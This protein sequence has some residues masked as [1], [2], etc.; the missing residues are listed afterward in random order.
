M[1]I[2]LTNDD[3]YQANGIHTLAKI[4]SK[5]GEVTVIA[6]KYTQSGMAMAINLTTKPIGYKFIGK[7][8]D[9]VSWAY[10]NSTPTAC[11]KYAL[12]YLVMKPDIIVSGI[13]H[14]SNAGA[15]S[16]YSG[17]LGACMEAAVNGLPSIGVS[18][19]D[20]TFI[21]DVDFS[22]VEQYFPEIFQ[23]IHDNLI[24]DPDASASSRAR[25]L[26]Y[27][28]NF[29]NKPASEFK[30]IKVGYQGRGRWVKE[31]VPYTGPAHPNIEEGESP[32]CISGIYIDDKK[33]DSNA[34]NIIMS[35]GY[36]AVSP[37]S[38]D[39]TDLDELERLKGIF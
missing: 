32:V 33:N 7:D 17:T 29:P 9:G 19:D 10:L 37:L 4:M 30:G 26:Y 38:I 22:M 14:G 21:G 28:V 25:C 31:F 5:F 12:N 16:L 18:I 23:K 1:K 11:I 39:K 20:D 13:N 6:P 27:N 8:E 2:L 36:V 3:G 24:M 34:D 35:E 15:A